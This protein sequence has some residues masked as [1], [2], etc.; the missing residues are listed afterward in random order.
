[1]YNEEKTTKACEMKGEQE[2]KKEIK[3][4]ISKSRKKKK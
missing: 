4:N 3:D 2:K 1:M